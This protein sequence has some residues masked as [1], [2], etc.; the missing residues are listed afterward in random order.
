MFYQE[1]MF[2]M[3]FPMYFWLV[4]IAAF[5]ISAIGF[6]NYIWFFSV[7]YGLAIAGEGLLL[8][9][10]YRQGLSAGTA[11]CC[12]LLAVYGL[13]LGGYLA[14]REIRLT[15]YHKH[16]GDDIKDSKT[17]P[18]AAKLSIWFFC[19]VLY[20]TMVCPVFYRLSNGSGSNA[21]TYIGA[22]LMLLGFLTEATADHQKKTAKAVHPHR[23]VDTGLYRFVR[24]PNYLGEVILWTGVLISGFGSLSGVGQWVLAILGY[25][26][27]L[28]VMFS[29][30]RR[31]ELRQDRTYGADPEYRT[32]RT[33]VPVLLPFVPLYS[34]VKYKWLVA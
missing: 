12:V 19:A 33:T 8:L 25:L 34:V 1:V 24:C 6:K 16:L 2:A 30:A 20:V 17:I 23:F 27:I 21:F 29:G 15:S 26:G 28:Y 3:V 11:L 22:A 10:L 5:A 7:G 31:L 13:R 32:Y 14:Y 18:F 9:F 4:V